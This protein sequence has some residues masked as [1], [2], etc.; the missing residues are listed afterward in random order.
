MI[1]RTQIELIDNKHEELT[2]KELLIPVDMVFR[3]DLVMS[4]REH[5]EEETNEINPD[6]CV[7]YFFEEKSFIIH[8]PYRE[9]VK[10][11]IE[12]NR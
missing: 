7:I 3:V 9:M 1:H 2:G 8:T 12:A 6:K 5:L 11:F 4:V 10:L